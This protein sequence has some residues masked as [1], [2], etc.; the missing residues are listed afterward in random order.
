MVVLQKTKKHPLLRKTVRNKYRKAGLAKADEMRGLLIKVLTNKDHGSLVKFHKRRQ[1]A[2][3]FTDQITLTQPTLSTIGKRLIRRFVKASRVT[4]VNELIKVEN[5]EE[6]TTSLLEAVANFY[7]GESLSSYQNKYL[8]SYGLID[9]NAFIA[10][11]FE[12]YDPNTEVARCYPVLWPCTQIV[13]YKYDTFGGLEYLLTFERKE[14]EVP[15]NA[16]TQASLET[17]KKTVIDYYLYERGHQTVYRQIVNG[18]DMAEFGAVGDTINFEVSNQPATLEATRFNAYYYE[19]YTDEIPARCLGYE[20]HPEDITIKVSPL[21]AAEPHFRDFADLKSKTDITLNNHVYARLMQYVEKCPGEN[22]ELGILCH[23]G[24]IPGTEETCKKC[25]G[26]GYLVHKSAM[27]VLYFKLPDSPADLL[28]LDKLAVYIEPEIKVLDKLTERLNELEFRKIPIAIFGTELLQRTD[29]S[30]GVANTATEV[31]LTADQIS[32]TLRPFVDNRSACYEFIVRQ[33]ALFR[34]LKEVTIFQR[35]P[36]DLAVESAGQLL[37]QLNKANESGANSFIIDMLN[38]KTMRTLLRDKKEE[39][40]RYEVQRRFMPFN[41]KTE[42]ERAL[43]LQSDLVP[44]KI[45]ILYLNFDSILDELEEELKEE[46]KDF[47][48]MPYKDQNAL[49]DTKIDVILVKLKD[50]NPPLT[51]NLTSIQNGRNQSNAQGGKGGSTGQG[52][53]QQDPNQGQNSN[54]GDPNAPTV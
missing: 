51:F 38:D 10:I 4:G 24:F 52:Q 3:Q 14:I 41:G 37:D 2:A 31:E 53:N 12:N 16:V 32:D 27:D 39:L 36:S 28:P 21:W 48:A 5:N 23:S 25:K 43:I 8:D 13:D 19:T 18:R 22:P 46:K 1:T 54:Q 6:A 50:E 44:K 9:A 29:G 26:T 20:V 40:R 15:I 7:A 47:Y 35:Y 11:H 17:Q 42:A 33:I 49:I 45:K 34:D 30:Q